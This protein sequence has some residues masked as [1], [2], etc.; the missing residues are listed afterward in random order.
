MANLGAGELDR[1]IRIMRRTDVEDDAGD[2]LEEEGWSLAFKRWAKRILPSSVSPTFRETLG[3]EEVVR[4]A[5]V[6]W[7]IRYDSQSLQIAPERYRVVY[8]GR[9]HEIVGIGEGAN[10][11]DGLILLTC[12]RPDDQGDRGQELET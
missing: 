4:S 9:I 1:R 7:K 2:I 6:L 5:D 8:G 10:R 12:Y 3:D 11:H